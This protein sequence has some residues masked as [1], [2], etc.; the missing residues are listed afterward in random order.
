MPSP[1]PP[2]PAPG[3]VA[4]PPPSNDY[5]RDQ[6]KFAPHVVILQEWNRVNEAMASGRDPMPAFLS[7]ATDL[8][9]LARDDETYHAD[10]DAADALVDSILAER[11]F[12]D[13]LSYVAI[14]KAVY[15]SVMERRGLLAGAR[16]GTPDSLDSLA[17]GGDPR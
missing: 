9:A 5:T 7:W 16:P 4:P 2:T 8:G 15:V 1:P 13:R 11:G 3:T 12:V 17:S 6:V 10:M 14:Y